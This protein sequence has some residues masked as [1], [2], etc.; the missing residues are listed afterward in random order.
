MKNVDYTNS[1]TILWSFQ[2]E[3]KPDFLSNT[4]PT[5]ALSYNTEVG[6]ILSN[7]IKNII[8][9]LDGNIITVDYR[10]IVPLNF[11]SIKK[12]LENGKAQAIKFLQNVDG[13]IIPGNDY[14]VYPELFGGDNESLGSS[15]KER[16]IGE[17]I[18]LDAAIQKGI[19][20]R[21]ICG[22][23]QLINV[24]FGSK[25]ANTPPRSLDYT[26]V[27]IEENS[28][29]A[30]IISNPLPQK[31]NAVHTQMVIE[32]DNTSLMYPTAFV[33]YPSSVSKPDII[34]ATESKHGVSI[35]SYQ[36]HP[37]S[38]NG[39]TKEEIE[40][41]MKIFK[42]Y[43]KKCK[44]YKF[45]QE[46][47]KDVAKSILEIEDDNS[48]N[49]IVIKKLF[50]FKNIIK[51]IIPKNLE[52]K[53]LSFE[54]IEIHNK[55]IQ[56]INI[57]NKINR[58][59]NENEIKFLNMKI[60]IKLGFHIDQLLNIESNQQK[61]FVE[62]G[63]N[64]EYLINKGFIINQL[65]SMKFEQQE[66]LIQNIDKIEKLSKIKGF[67]DKLYSMNFGQQKLFI[68]NISKIE[69]LSVVKIAIDQ[70]INLN[71][72]QQKLFVENIDKVKILTITKVSMDQFINL[73]F[74]QQRFF[75]ENLKEVRN[76]SK[77]STKT[78]INQ[79]L[80]LDFPKQKLF[81]ENTKELSSLEGSGFSIEKIFNVDFAKQIFFIKNEEQLTR[82]SED[83][84]A[85]E[86]LFTM[87]NKQQ[88]EYLINS[89][90]LK[91][92]GNI[93]NLDQQLEVDIVGVTCEITA[94]A[95]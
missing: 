30:H 68:E 35:A 25:L 41:N 18:L 53:Y 24:Y 73:N 76:I 9:Q 65:L 82:L 71:F 45:E 19:P 4:K 14:A 58:N 79:F 26:K 89:Q 47:L 51:K 12:V 1:E 39:L 63:K 32:I 44:D 67:T 56:Q 6:G 37:E 57:E 11:K 15:D 28:E 17:M 61:L 75:M 95:T 94:P 2:D 66:L 8:T 93:S 60:L 31:F 13:L 91:E 3:Q 33:K 86:L 83:G 77:I 84:F 64:I 55:L 62:N 85:E 69:E 72:D 46:N 50:N 22:G 27:I 43:L 38:I 36:F 88:L 78:A 7:E 81:I 49:D 92:S 34:V 80:K 29:L 21:G 74:E 40:R 23:H 87:E 59:L 48:I 10:K 70:F 90:V 54:E 20:I 16:S 42:T 5:I 52:A